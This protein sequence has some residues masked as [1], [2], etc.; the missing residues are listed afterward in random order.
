MPGKPHPFVRATL[1]RAVRKVVQDKHDHSGP[2][3]FIACPQCVARLWEAL[4]RV[5]PREWMGGR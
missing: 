5:A 1:T 2:A 4:D 3:E